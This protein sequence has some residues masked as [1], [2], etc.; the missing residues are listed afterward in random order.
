MP[1]WLIKDQSQNF[2]HA[3]TFFFP[4]ELIMHLLLY[5]LSHNNYVAI[6][7]PRSLTRVD[8]KWC[9]SVLLHLFIRILIGLNSSITQ[10]D[11]HYC[12]VAWLTGNVVGYTSRG[13]GFDFSSLPL[14]LGILCNEVYFMVCMC[15]SVLFT[16]STLC[17][18]WRKPLQCWSQVRGGLS[19]VLLFL[20]MVQTIHCKTLVTVDVKTIRE[21]ERERQ[22]DKV[23][24]R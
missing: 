13:T 2:S 22:I 9:Y 8:R 21:S 6:T 10:N 23:K 7:W 4:Y 24:D 3:W 12:S 20:Y 1:S 18:L 17:Y 11:Y 14:Q 5:T 16:F 15:C 19:I